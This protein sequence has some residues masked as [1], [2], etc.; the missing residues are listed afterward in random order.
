MEPTEERKAQKSIHVAPFREVVAHHLDVIAGKSGQS[1][2]LHRKEG[3]GLNVAGC[4]QRCFFFREPWPVA[5]RLEN[6]PGESVYVAPVSRA[7]VTQR[8]PLGP[9][10][11]TSKTMTGT[12]GSKRNSGMKGHRK[13]LF[14]NFPRVGDVVIAVQAG[15]LGVDVV[16]VLAVKDKFSLNGPALLIRFADPDE[17]PLVFVVLLDTRYL[18]IHGPNSFLAFLLEGSIPHRRISRKPGWAG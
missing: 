5:D 4:D 2:P 1:D 15:L 16:S 3:D 8:L 18:V 12:S 13:T 10:I 17:K 11:T 7:A 9:S 6:F 14:R